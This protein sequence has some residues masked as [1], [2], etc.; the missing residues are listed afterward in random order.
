MVFD[1]VLKFS[2]KFVFFTFCVIKDCA[3]GTAMCI[4]IP[5]TLSNILKTKKVEITMK[6]RIW[7]GTLLEVG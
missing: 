6:S 7:N 1:K 4:S 5:C 2:V 3:N